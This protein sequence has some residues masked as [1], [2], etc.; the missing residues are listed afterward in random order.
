MIGGLMELKSGSV[1]SPAAVGLNDSDLWRFIPLLYIMQAVP[2]T[3]V[4]EVSTIVYKD[5]GVKNTDITLWTSIIALPWAMQMLLGPFVDLN[6]TK[7]RWILG[8]QMFIGIALGLMVFLLQ[9]PNAFPITLVNLGLCGF[10]SALCN[11]AS[12]GFYIL[13]SSKEQQAKFAGIQSTCYRLGRLF[14]T[15]I[16]VALSGYFMKVLHMTP[17]V[18]WGAVFAV[19]AGWYGLGWLFNGRV[20]P[21]P[22]TDRPA[23]EQKPGENQKNLARTGI[24]VWVGVCGYF[25]ISAG[26]SL[27]GQII[28]L[29]FD[30]TEDG[31]L[32]SI[33][34]SGFQ[35]L[36]G[37]D[38]YRAD[39]QLFILLAAC[40]LAALGLVAAGRTL[41]NTP[42]GDAF[43]TFV[44]QPGIWA[45]FSF[46]LFYRFSE[47]MVS[48]MSPLFLKDS[49]VNGGMAVDNATLGG[50][51]GV[52]GVIGIIVGGILGGLI[53]SRFGFKKV[54][55]PLAF[56]MHLPN[57]LYW[58]ASLAKPP[59]AVLYGVD[60]AENFGYGLGFAAYMVFLMRV[61]SRGNYKTSHYAIG[62]G[63]GALCIAAAGIVSGI[64][65]QNFGYTGFFAASMIFAIPGLISLLFIPKDIQ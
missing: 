8:G 26:G 50:I 13:A 21:T 53:L 15:G 40:G 62:T 36:F 16:L 30:G 32:K 17:S 47:A 2:V 22:D 34:L 42:M 12:D 23:A 33:H 57:L 3:L 35:N 63:M 11:I 10:A 55:W 52:A 20:I 59:I 38:Y 44:H 58:W 48:K 56:A 7:R 6:G 51:K 29:A 28:W 49:L 1:E 5:L 27:L 54:I 39:A 25:L 4:Q 65:Q 61:A 31:P 64:V 19:A 45:I 46:I 14:C 41:R 60:F 37:T 43:S 24:V 18:A 9:L